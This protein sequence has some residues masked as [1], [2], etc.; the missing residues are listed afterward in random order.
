VAV[1]RPEEDSIELPF[2]FLHIV[3]KNVRIVEPKQ[4]RH[5]GIRSIVSP[6]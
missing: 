5:R 1:V 3:P 4:R 6:T 2:Y